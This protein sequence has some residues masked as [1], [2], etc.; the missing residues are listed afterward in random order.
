MTFKEKAAAAGRAGTRYLLYVGAVAGAVAI[1]V[2]PAWSLGYFMCA[3]IAVTLVV[4][5]LA[6]I[7]RFRQINLRSL[8]TVILELV[9]INSVFLS[10]EFFAA[11]CVGI[12]V[13]GTMRLYGGERPTRIATT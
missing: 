5:V 3:G 6:A 9:A 7:G 8:L 12:L 10:R 13:T 11:L 2:E 4:L 1:V